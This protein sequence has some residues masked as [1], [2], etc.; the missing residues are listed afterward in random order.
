MS[1]IVD[2]RPSSSAPFQF[3]ATLDGVVHTV[4]ATWNLYGRRFYVN[5]Y[6]LAG[7]LVTARPL[8]GSP[9]GISIQGLSWSRGVATLLTKTPH[10]FPVGAVLD[11]SVAGMLP[12][13]Y[14]GTYRCA[15]QDANT[16]T[17]PLATN[18]GDASLFGNV[19]YDINLVAGYFS[20]STLVYREAA[21]QFEVRP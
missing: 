13:A 18:P 3:N 19:S 16:V 12:A 10:D 9:T 7:T 5:V 20:P 14:N 6:D 2:F 11:L 8:I 17:Y 15:V 1:A 4:I 21:R